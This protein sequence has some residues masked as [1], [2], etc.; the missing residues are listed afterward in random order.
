MPKWLAKPVD[1]AKS[2]LN[3]IRSVGPFLISQSDK[4]SEALARH[5]ARVGTVEAGKEIL[6]Q[7]I[8]T[9]SDIKKKLLERYVDADSEQR[10]GIRRDLDEIGASLRRLNIGIQSL[11]YLPTSG[12]QAPPAAP[13]PEVSAHWMDKFSELARARNEP[14]REDLLAR[15]LAQESSTPGTIS[16]RLLWLIGTMEGEPFHAFAT[17]LDLSTRMN[18]H[19]MIPGYKAFLEH[20]VPDCTLGDN[21]SIG[22]LLFKLNDIG[23]IADIATSFR[24]FRIGDHY[25]VAYGSTCLTIF[26]KTNDLRI[27]GIIPSE[28]GRSL[29]LLYQPKFNVLGQRIFDAWI[30]SLDTTKF[31]TESLV[32][33]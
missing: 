21:V 25:I 14:W 27:F 2:T 4:A 16:P 26:C 17:I 10:I 18:G 1:F 5:Q 23:L 6:L 19:L 3:V 29:S 12:D 32:T 28:L 22:N 33:P 7:E 15:T 8:H 31:P 9:Y 13:L 30:E 24:L 11:N 20:H